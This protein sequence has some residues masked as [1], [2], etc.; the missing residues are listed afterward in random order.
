M[1]LDSISPLHAARDFPELTRN[2]F[3]NNCYSQ[4]EVSLSSC[5]TKLV[6]KNYCTVCQ[7]GK[8]CKV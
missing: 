7:T 6:Q 2:H 3:Y 4:G 8:F 1:K 5:Y